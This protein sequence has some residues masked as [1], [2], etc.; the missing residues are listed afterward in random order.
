[1]AAQTIT[2]TTASPTPAAIV[3]AADTINLHV[4]GEFGNAGQ[5]QIEVSPDGSLPYAPVSVHQASVGAGRHAA[6]HQFV[7]RSGW[8]LK[9]KLL[10]SSLFGT[11][12]SGVNVVVAV[13]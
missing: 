2:V 8:R 4:S 9:A 10:Q 12:P 6:T 11:Y 5:I 3:L 7:C 13:E 1:M